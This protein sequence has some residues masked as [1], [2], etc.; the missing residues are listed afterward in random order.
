M[1]VLAVTLPSAAA[2]AAG[3]RRGPGPSLDPPA[4][5]RHRHGADHQ[6]HHRL[7]PDRGVLRRPDPRRRPGLCRLRSGHRALRQPCG[8]RP[9]PRRDPRLHRA[10]GLHG[11][12]P[13]SGWRHSGHR[14]LDHTQGHDV[15]TRADVDM[16]ARHI[17]LL[18]RLRQHADRGPHDAAHP[19]SPQGVAR[20]ARLH[21]RFDRGA[22]GQ[23]RA[24]L[25][26]DRLRDWPRPGCLQQPGARPQRLLDDRCVHPLPLLPGLCAGAGICHCLLR[27][28][29]WPHAES[30][31]ARR[32]RQGRRRRPGT[33]WRLQR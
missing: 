1:S 2:D 14:R 20:E 19:R 8:R 21:R 31:A 27:T 6:R 16:A 25:D 17:D 12:S 32:H 5:H 33:T 26:L 7:A 29:L 24:D 30:R 4:D 13:Q 11:R 23:H 15:D 3:E 22:S 28:R 9:G 18:R 10:P